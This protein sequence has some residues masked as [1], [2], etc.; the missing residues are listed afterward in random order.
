M[1]KRKSGPAPLKFDLRGGNLEFFNDTESPELIIAAAAGTGKSLAACLKLLNLLSTYPQSRALI[2]RKT[3]ASLTESGLVTWEDDVL[4]GRTAEYFGNTKRTHRHSYV[5]PNKSELVGGGMDNVL[6]IF[7]TSYDIVYVQEA[8]ELTE[9]EW[10]SLLRSLRNGRMPFQQLMGDTNPSH[11]MHWIKRRSSGSHPGLKLLTSFHRDNPALYDGEQWTW[12]GKDY[13]EKKLGALTGM[14]RRRLLNGEWCQAEGVVFEEWTEYMEDKPW[15]VI[16]WDDLPIPKEYRE[17]STLP[18]DWPR[19]IAIDFGW[20]QPSVVMFGAQ[21]HDK[22]MYVYRQIIRTGQ[23]VEDMAKEIKSSIA[24]DGVPP[25]AIFCDHDAEGRAT[26]ERHLGITTKKAYKD[27]LDTIDC[28]NS[29]LRKGIDGR[30]RLCVV[31]DS[32]VSHDPRMKERGLP[33]GLIE[34]IPAY[35]WLDSK[36]REIPLQENDHAIDALRYLVG[37]LYR[38]R[39]KIAVRVF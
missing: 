16:G 7:S 38:A 2:L 8:V 12:R 1:K 31:R 10:E 23:L 21:D 19:F 4:Q 30:P 6:K 13:L 35:V 3:R 37:T 17:R 27:I 15:H 9:D 25:Q 26:L 36:T 18:P 29:M 22:R 28:V 5:F 11:P 33:C 39:R 20:D 24:E 14:R 32:L 34:E